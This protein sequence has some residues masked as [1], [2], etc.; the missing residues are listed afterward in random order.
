MRLRSLILSV[1]LLAGGCATRLP[2]DETE[3]SASR[4][5]SPLLTAIPAP[6][7]RADTALV[8]KRL[9]MSHACFVPCERACGEV[10][11][12]F[13]HHEIAIF[14]G[15]TS[16][17]GEGGATIGLDYAYWFNERFGVGPFFDY[18]TGEV[19]A[20][21][22]G[23]GVWVRPL[24][25]LSALSFYVAPGVDIAHEEKH[26]TDEGRSWEASALLRLGAAYGW[27]WG[28]GSG[29]CRLSTWI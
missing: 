17:R 3:P 29:S 8:G 16:E 1:A 20:F 10:E 12:E 24:N 14:L 25:R 13:K 7:Y 23:A 19:D 11:E 21:A 18:V 4:G 9:S 22:F 28:G 27:A 5:S 6:E 15:Y 2:I 26:G